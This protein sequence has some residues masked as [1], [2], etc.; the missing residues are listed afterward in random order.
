MTKPWA[1]EASEVERESPGNGCGEE[2]E[3]E[4]RKRLQEETLNAIGTFS[5]RDRLPREQ[6]HRRDELR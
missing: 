4:C 2:T 5:A 3:F 6:V 1:A